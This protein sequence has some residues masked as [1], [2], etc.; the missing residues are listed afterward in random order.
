ME[1]SDPDDNQAD[2][3]RPKPVFLLLLDGWG[4]AETSETNAISLA[5]APYILKLIKEYPAT[6]LNSASGSLNNRYLSLGSGTKT[7]SEDQFVHSDLTTILSI[8]GLKQ[9]KIFDS[10]R[11]AALSYF[12][13]GRREEKAPLE[14]WLT[15]S[16]ANKEKS[17]DINLSC[18]KIFQEAVKAVKSE[19]YDFIVA[20]C[21]ILDY[22]ASSGDLL[23]TADAVEI[24][25][26]AVKKIASEIFDRNGI[27][28]LSS[29]HGNAEK[30]KN[31]A[32]GF[33]D[34]DITD[35]PVP[36]IIISNTFKGLSISSLDAPEG[37]LSLLNPAGSIADVVPTIIDIL[38]LRNK[39]KDYFL[40]QSLLK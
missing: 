1:V 40:G 18:K 25:D 26:K 39:R 3:D 6:V 22:L 21:S 16:S 14:D 35:N 13:N 12:F 10:E 19:S 36:F 7:L 15:V 38:G 31:L 28:L 23:K 30:I 17:F 33:P 24:V 20:S 8:Q 5:K 2:I 32:I 29:V 11:L 37:D 34:K 27:L 9:L 4:V